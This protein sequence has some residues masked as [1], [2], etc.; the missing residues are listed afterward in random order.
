MMPFD[1]QKDF[2]SKVIT[3]TNMNDERQSIYHE[4]IFIQFESIITN[5]L[6]LF[7]SQIQEELLSQYIYDFINYGS[8][9][10]FVWK[11]IFEFERFLIDTKRVKLKNL[12]DILIFELKE[13]KIYSLD[14][15]I[16][17]STFAWNKKY[18]L[19]HNVHIMKSNIDIINQT[20]IKQ[21]QYSLIYKSK[22]DFEVYHID[23]SL[24]IFQFLSLLKSSI[25]ANNIL[26]IVCRRLNLK[27][28][29]V[30]GILID[31]LKMFTL[32]GIIVKNN[33]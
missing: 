23:L 1:I 15:N 11:I 18:I 6:P 33:N 20:F 30:K 24:L 26:K 5:A 12:K 10:P 31:T 17:T 4:L 9:T 21:K 8:K 19:N 3:N 14:K 28:A 25:N 16:I 22:D 2:V 27:F 29:E 7:C 13:I 32:N